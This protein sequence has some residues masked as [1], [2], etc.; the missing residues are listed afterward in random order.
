MVLKLVYMVVLAVFAM[1]LLANV[2]TPHDLLKKHRRGEEGGISIMPQLEI[3]LLGLLTGLAGAIDQSGS[4]FH[5]KAT[6]V[7]LGG[8]TLVSWVCM[9]AG[10][11]LTGWMLSRTEPD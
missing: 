10:T 9:V 4:L 7:W 2:L 11:A 3:V 1:K 8:A 6:L 5:W